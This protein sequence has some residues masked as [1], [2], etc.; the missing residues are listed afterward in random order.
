MCPLSAT[1]AERRLPNETVP[2]SLFC[3]CFGRWENEC[4]DDA[5]YDFY[6]D[7][8]RWIWVKCAFLVCEA[9][10]LDFP[11]LVTMDHRDGHAPY[12]REFDFYRRK[13]TRH[14][15]VETGPRETI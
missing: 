3:G 4:A 11:V 12:A 5:N 14:D 2:K 8:R 10:S 6:V 15:T 7:E 1:N 13:W 9:I